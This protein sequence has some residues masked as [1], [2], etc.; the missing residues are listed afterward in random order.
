MFVA[1]APHNAIYYWDPLGIGTVTVFGEYI[2]PVVTAVSPV[3]GRVEG[4]TNMTITGS[5]FIGASRLTIGGTNVTGF[6]VI[7]DTTLVCVSPPQVAPGAVSVEVTTPGG[8]N[9]ANTLFTY[10]IPNA[11]PTFTLPASGGPAAGEVW[12]PRQSGAPTIDG[13]VSS[14]RKSVV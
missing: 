11:P 8:T 14:D 7:N 3:W 4:G 1:G 9:V 2:T 5:E 6:T 13:L 12:T 10:V